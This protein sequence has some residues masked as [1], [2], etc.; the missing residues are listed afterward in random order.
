LQVRLRLGLR[1][2]DLREVLAGVDA[3]DE[4]LGAR[5]RRRRFVGR[6]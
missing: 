3:V 6:G 1:E 5:A 4:G 2:R